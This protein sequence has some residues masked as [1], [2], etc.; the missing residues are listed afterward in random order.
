[1]KTRIIIAILIGLSIGSCKKDNTK[2]F[3]LLMDKFNE[4]GSGGNTNCS[5]EFDIVGKW[6][7]TSPCG[8][9]D[10]EK[11][12]FYCPNSSGVKRGFLQRPDCNNIC[13][14]LKWDFTY[15]ISNGVCYLD[16]DATNNY[17]SCGQPVPPGNDA[18]FTYSVSGNTLTTSFGTYY[19]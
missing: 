18:S 9:L 17:E 8:S 16:Y 14:P 13:E 11:I 6:S 15:T 3:E 19:K 2:D 5:S 4:S 12:E 1:M 7:A 10:D